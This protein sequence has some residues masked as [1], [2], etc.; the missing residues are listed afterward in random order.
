MTYTKG[1]TYL[2]FILIIIAASCSNTRHL[3]A[4]ETLFIGSNIKIQDHEASH[5]ERKT[6]STDLEGA[7]RP[8]PNSKTLGM[9]FKLRLYEF[10]GTTKKK[11]GIKAFLRKSGEE[12]V[13]ASSV[14]LQTNK[15]IMVNLLQNKGFF[16]ATV[17]P[18][19]KTD[20]K[21]RTTAVFNVTT[22]PQYTINKTIFLKDSTEPEITFDIDSTFPSTLLTPGAPYNLDLIKAERNRIDKALK[23]LGYYWFKPDYIIVQADTTIGN[24]KV[25]MYV[26]VKKEGVP[27]QAYQ[28]SYIGDIYVYPNFKTHGKETDTNKANAVL[29]K[30]YNIVD[31]KKSFKP[32]IFWRAIK[33]EKGDE[34]NLDDQNTSLN[35]LVTMGT[36][37]FVKSRY[38]PVNDSVLDVFYFLT[39]FPRKSLQFEIGALTQNDNRAGTQGSIS[40]RNRNAFKGA[41]ALIFKI[42]GG[43]EAQYTGEQKQPNIYNLGAEVDLSIPHFVIPFVEQQTNSLF[44]PHT[45]IK[46]S[47]NYES[48]SDLLR[49][50]SYKLSYGYDW[51]QGYKQEHQL[52]PFNFTYVRTDTLTQNNSNLNL[53]YGNLIFNGIIIGPTYEFT[54]NSQ[55]GPPR[56]NSF[57]FDGL[58]DLSGNLLG[59]AEKADY[60]TNPQTLLGQTYAQYLKFQPDFRY[61]LRLSSATTIATRLLMGLGIPY[62]NSSQLPNIKQFWAGGNSDLRGFQSRLVGPG[63]FDYRAQSERYLETL[64]DIK[65]ELN[66]ELR[67]NIY[68]FF[69]AAIF[70]DAGNIWLYHNNPDYPGGKFTS[71]FYKEVAADVGVGLRFDIKILLLRL[72]LGMPVRE[73]YLPEEDRWV[74]NKI[75][76]SSSSWRRQNLVFNIG[77]GYPF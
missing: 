23:Q 65:G 63:T 36:F 61:Y 6:L 48:Q 8:R 53:L 1:Y 40:W 43:F 11:K 3:P 19:F 67:Q 66:I 35:R 31:P 33:F 29:Y 60:K 52:Y 45:L 75:D 71:S 12:P 37:K 5:K 46:A 54:Y 34:Y 44:V 16:Y 17:N 49:I 70:Y 13:L 39:P 50:N 9:R 30:G 55:V 32:A 24:H 57:Y 62:G 64:G 76:F 27:D 74:F 58:I 10:A 4:G 42:N 51:K 41:E 7:V 21:K 69:N 59:L 20:K 2:L 47:Y 15:A 68:K 25:D 18:I 56:K 22:G 77:I 14:N 38:D 26:A 72:D 73:P 28:V